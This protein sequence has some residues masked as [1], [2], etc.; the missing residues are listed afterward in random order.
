MPSK[1]KPASTCFP[2]ILTPCILHFLI[3]CY[4]GD[5]FFTFVVMC[6]WKWK[7]QPPNDCIKNTTYVR[8]VGPYYMTSPKWRQWVNHKI[9][10][11]DELF[12]SSS[13][14][15]FCYIPIEFTK[16]IFSAELFLF[17]SSM[18]LVSDILLIESF[19]L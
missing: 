14:I 5:I 17:Y 9:F 11:M 4:Y 16:M 15:Q 3:K 18:L 10:Q 2:L 19:Y 8:E 6:W 7:S 1:L 12:N 13:N